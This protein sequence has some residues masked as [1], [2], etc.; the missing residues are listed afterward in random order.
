MLDTFFLS[1]F[2]QICVQCLHV[3]GVIGGSVLG[4]RVIT[5]TAE[6]AGPMNFW[7][8][9]QPS[10]SIDTYHG[11][12]L[13]MTIDREKCE[14]QGVIIG[15]PCKLSIGYLTITLKNV[16]SYK[17]LRV[18]DGRVSYTVFFAPKCQFPPLK[19]GDV[20]VEPSMPLHRF[21]KGK[22][23]VKIEFA[24]FGTNQSR[25]IRI[26]KGMDP[27]CMWNG[28]VEISKNPSCEDMTIDAVRNWMIF[29]TTIYRLSEG[30]QY[31][32]YSWGSN[33]NDLTVTLDW[34]NEGEALEVEEC[35]SK[36][37][38][39]PHSMLRTSL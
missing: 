29:K 11:T 3:G 6:S 35:R 1:L 22:H 20:V 17:V 30:E 32:T 16:T 8:Q 27:I 7:L 18:S 37:T 5:D 10:C 13:A 25:T 2:L 33:S 15:Q 24:V 26:L 12:A 21:L 34:T 9:G 39:H 14:S 28:N 19:E 4:S 36:F 23:Q 31:V 38:E